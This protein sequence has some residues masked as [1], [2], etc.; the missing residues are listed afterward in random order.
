M[1]IKIRQRY[2]KESILYTFIRRN[3]IDWNNVQDFRNA[4]I[5]NIKNNLE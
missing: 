3:V 1:A 4:S 2:E 5:A